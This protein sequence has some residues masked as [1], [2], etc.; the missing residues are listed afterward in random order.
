MDAAKKAIDARGAGLS[1]V[2]FICGTQV[3]PCWVDARFS[4]TLI[5]R[6]RTFTRI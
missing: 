1:S 6:L 4:F 3:D 5:D 2:R